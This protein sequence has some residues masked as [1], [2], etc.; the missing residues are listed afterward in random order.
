MNQL[1]HLNRTPAQEDAAESMRR[2]NQEFERERRIADNNGSNMTNAQ[3]SRRLQRAA[4]F[5]DWR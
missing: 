3:I 2:Q 1:N 5:S 4:A